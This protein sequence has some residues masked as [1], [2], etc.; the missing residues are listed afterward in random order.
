MNEKEESAQI[1][2]YLPVLLTK[3]RFLR[4]IYLNNLPPEQ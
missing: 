2:I 4:Y 3:I 1:Q